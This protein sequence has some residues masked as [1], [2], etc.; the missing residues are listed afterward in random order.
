MRATAPLHRPVRSTP[1]PASVDDGRQLRRAP[2][3]SYRRALLVGLG[4]SLALHLLIVLIARRTWL[5]PVPIE[6]PEAPVVAVGG[7]RTTMRVE[8]IVIVPEARA[9]AEATER[10]EP[11]ERPEPEAEPAPVTIPGAVDAA[12]APGASA[13][14]RLRPRM[15]DPRLWTRPELPPPEEPS[16]IEV[17]RARIARRIQ[18]WND[19][20]AAEAGRAADA[21]DWTVKDGEGKRW[22][23]S[24]G[25]IHLGDLTIPVPVNIG[26]GP[27]PQREKAEE[28]ASRDKEVAAQAERAAADEN[29][30]E[31]VRAIRERKDQERREQKPG[32]STAGSGN[33]SGSA[34]ATGGGSG[35]SGG[36]GTG[37]GS[38][39]G[40]G[41]GGSG[42]NRPGGD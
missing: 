2:R 36:S 25:K 18:E 10:V 19:S 30:E 34:G 7:E 37:P 41:N 6:L 22:G 23:I 13:L 8:R 21:M 24:P 14:D 20:V 40:S 26:G 38:G 9:E 3:V 15:A 1:P 32:G 31:R 28:R 17:V 39:A 42:G 4:L 12:P 16:D 27:S 5:V 35:S 29:R 11:E 33:G